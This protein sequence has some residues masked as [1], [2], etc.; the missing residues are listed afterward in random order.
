MIAHEIQRFYFSLSQD[1]KTRRPQLYTGTRGLANISCTRDVCR[2]FYS[3]DALRGA[4]L[5]AGQHKKLK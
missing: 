2:F 3:D 5:I 4:L 1:L